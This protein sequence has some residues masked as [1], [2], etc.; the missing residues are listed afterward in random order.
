MERTIG[1]NPV[2]SWCV[3]STIDFGKRFV[4]LVNCFIVTWCLCSAMKIIRLK[5]DVIRRVV[6]ME[7]QVVEE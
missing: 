5:C 7:V 3:I 4:K 6:R 2:R 1:V